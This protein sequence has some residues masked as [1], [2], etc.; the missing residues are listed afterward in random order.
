M[1]N[2][3]GLANGAFELW[4]NGNPEARAA[5]LNFLGTFSS[6]GIN[7]VFF[8]NY[9]NNGAPATQERYF[10]NIVVSTRRIGCAE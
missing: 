2:D 4:V 1:L 5:S 8:E 10:D 9:W 7:A 6:Y 3:P